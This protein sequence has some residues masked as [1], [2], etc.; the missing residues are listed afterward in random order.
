MESCGLL[1]CFYLILTAPIHC[2]VSIGEQI[3][4][5]DFSKSVPMKKQS[6]L[7]W[8]EGEYIFR[9]RSFLDELLMWFYL[10]YN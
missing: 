6:H 9:K 3:S 1:G 5:L 10:Y 7:G 4:M 8:P 2:R